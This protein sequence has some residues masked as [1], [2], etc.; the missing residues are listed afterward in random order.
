VNMP[1]C[2]DLRQPCASPV[3]PF[4]Y[5]L[6][7]M[8][9]PGE[10]VEA[11][12]KRRCKATSKRGEPCRAS[13]V[14]ASGY[15]AVHDPERPID[16]RELGHRGGKARRRGVAE[17][18][19]A[20]ERESLREKLR[21]Q[22]DHNLVKTAIERALAG[23]NESARVAAVKFL[24]DLELYKAD[25]DLD[26]RERM[27][28]ELAAAREQFDELVRRHV[29]VA[30]G[31][32]ERLRPAVPRRPPHEPDERRGGWDRTNEA[33]GACRPRRLRD[34]PG[35]HQPGRRDVPRR[36]RAARR[37]A[38]WREGKR[39]AARRRGG[40]NEP[41]SGEVTDWVKSPLQ[42]LSRS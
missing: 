19:P 28:G 24:A 31:E 42:G 33:D 13:V 17:Q 36:G 26:W 10:R 11:P 9:T 1:I 21:D 37:A 18:L 8:R 35:L 27:K 29:Q 7:A 16:M 38:V 14:G 22:L 23:G 34:D 32:G 40:V 25:G 4:A 41:G 2:R 6:F 20:A 15:C 12:G 30:G 5:D 3:A 39:R